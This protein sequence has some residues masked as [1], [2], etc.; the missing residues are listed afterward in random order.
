MTPAVV[1]FIALGAN[2]DD[3]IDQIRQ[4]F[5]RLAELPDSRL[6]ASS[7]LYRTAPVGAG[8]EHHPDYINA[9]AKLE[10][11]LESGV[12]LKNL[13]A[14]EARQGRAR[15]ADVMAPRTLDLDL[16]LYGEERIDTAELTVPHPRMA[17][18]AFVLVPLAEIAP[19]LDVPGLGKLQALLPA[20]AGQAIVKLP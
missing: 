4:G 19:E 16:L 5:A 12:L 13:Q 20:V 18:R 14:I 3:P 2:L 1:A 17:E 7:S 15:Q 9:V 6:L 10:T 11:R 8:T